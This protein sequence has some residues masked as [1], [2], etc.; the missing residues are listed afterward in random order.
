[1][2]KRKRIGRPAGR[3]PLLNLRIDQSLYDDLK[4]AA[5]G[6]L[7]E[8]AVRRL[9]QSFERDKEFGRWR[10]LA[11][12]MV[13]G[14]A[15]GGHRRAAETEVPGDWRTNPDCYLFAVRGVL[16]ALVNAAPPGLDIETANAVLESA[17][18]RFATVAI[19]RGSK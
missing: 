1:M 4:V 17:K 16:E 11:H 8:E 9:R 3:K 12:V 13:S 7:S 15:N 19:S 14:F 2:A 10:Q 5:E 6:T 18:G